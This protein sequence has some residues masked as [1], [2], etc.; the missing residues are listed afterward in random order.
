MILAKTISDGKK[1][2][3][4]FSVSGK[5]NCGMCNCNCGAQKTLTNLDNEI[6]NIIK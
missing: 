2:S 3:K 4:N 1:F 6:K 5:C